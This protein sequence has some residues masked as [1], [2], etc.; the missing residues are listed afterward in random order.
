MQ[1]NV[2]QKWI[3]FAFAPAT[4][5]PVTGDA[6]NITAN[7]RIDG[8][9]ANAVDDTNPT[10]LEDGFYVFDTTAAE[11]NGDNLVLCPVSSTSGVQVIGVPGA[12]WTTPPNFPTLSI[13][14]NGR[15]DVIMVAGT[16]QT[17]RDLG[18][19]VLVGDKTGFSLSEAGI[20]AI[21]DDAVEG[22]ITLRQAQRLLIALAAAICNGGGTATVNY[23]DQ[24][25]TKNRI[26]LGGLDAN[27][28]RTSV[29]ID[30][31]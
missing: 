3:V 20:D 31:T 26:T 4:N 23:R 11:S 18:A 14:A 25:D 15:T 8:G 22:T 12:V 17:A 16:T 1:K 24:A 19:S 5:L 13:D 10:E 6:A 28:N 2:A 27:G 30:L 29:T 21:L 7:I 9:A